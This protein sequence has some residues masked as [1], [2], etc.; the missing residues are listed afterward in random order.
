MARAAEVVGFGIPGR[1]VSEGVT[2]GVDAQRGEDDVGD[3]L[4]FEL[5]LV[6]RTV[7]GIAVE[8]GVGDLVGEGLGLLSDGE[9]GAD[10]NPAQRVGAVTLG[11]AEQLVKAHGLKGC[12]DPIRWKGG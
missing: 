12:C 1:E 10:P 7:E 5:R 3:T 2:A 8:R 9:A 6:A 4:R 11:L